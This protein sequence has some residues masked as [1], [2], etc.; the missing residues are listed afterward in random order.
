VSAK[1]HYFEALMYT[2]QKTIYYPSRSSSVTLYP[3]TDTHIGARACDERRLK[4]D[5]DRI[6]DDPLAYWFHIGDVI[7]CIARKG[8]K[9]YNEE[10][11][12]EWLWGENDA[13]GVQRDYSLKT[14]KP[15]AGKC[16]GWGK[17]NHEEAALTYLDRDVYRDLV[18]HMAREAMLEPDELAFGV[19]GFISI[20]FRRG[21]PKAYHDSWRLN[22]YLFH[23]SGGGRLPGG[24]ALALGRVL[25][26]YDCDIALMG[27]RHVRQFV[28][29]TVVA[30]GKRGFSE[31]YRAAMFVASYLN[32]YIIP[33]SKKMPI[34]TYPE[35]KGL[36]PQALG[37]TPIVIYPDEREFDF[38]VGSG[39]T[40][41]APAQEVE[42][43]LA[44]GE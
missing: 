11:V 21:T 33:A 38:V 37:T 14:F 8:D 41:P 17:G 22:L 16:L 18:Y 44:V 2:L 28:D 23:G 40:V 10:T 4:R 5:I 3:I 34:D 19:Q 36:P 20:R 1:K 27:H 12:A 42:L 29:K 39:R 30:P 35:H 32:A 43:A 15:I 26:D 7:D 24:H 13:I 25:G 6:A 31:R 9:R